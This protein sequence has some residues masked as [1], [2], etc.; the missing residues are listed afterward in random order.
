MDDASGK[1][2]LQGLDIDKAKKILIDRL[3][4]IKTFFELQ[5]CTCV[6]ML[7]RILLVV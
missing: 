3:Y 1:D 4:E 7:L 2:D 6:R 5:K